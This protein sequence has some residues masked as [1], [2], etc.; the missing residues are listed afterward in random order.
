MF[1]RRAC[2]H[3][4]PIRF[5]NITKK[6]NEAELNTPKWIGRTEKKAATHVELED[7]KIESGQQ[8]IGLPS[9]TKTSWSGTDRSLWLPHQTFFSIRRRSIAWKAS[10]SHHRLFQIFLFIIGHCT[11]QNPQTSTSVFGLALLKGFKRKTA[12]KKKGKG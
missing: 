7:F 8:S 12:V 3:Q 6:L 9:H 11:T 10:I 4:W 2:S 5:K 1:V